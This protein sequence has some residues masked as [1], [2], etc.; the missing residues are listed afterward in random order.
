M[1]IQFFSSFF[2]MNFI[3]KIV[4]KTCLIMLK[5]FVVCF[6]LLSALCQNRFLISS[7]F[8][9]KS[10]LTNFKDIAAFKCTFCFN[11]LSF[12]IYHR[13]LFLF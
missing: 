10:Y 6:L 1:L 3:R 2:C 12:F 7:I 9:S 8:Y 11:Y 13:S 5:I 4:E